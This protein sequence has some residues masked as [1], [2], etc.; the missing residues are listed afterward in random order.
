MYRGSRAR[1][2]PNAQPLQTLLLERM[3]HDLPHQ[4][5]AQ[6]AAIV[7]Q[8]IDDRQFDAGASFSRSMFANS[9]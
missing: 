9:T 5:L 2:E 8:R 7:S 6:V 3:L 1:V 4:G